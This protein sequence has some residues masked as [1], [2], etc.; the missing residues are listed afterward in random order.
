MRWYLSYAL[1]VLLIFILW[2]L[3]Y[4]RNAH[5]AIPFGKESSTVIASSDGLLK[6]GRDERTVTGLGEAVAE[7][8]RDAEL[9][10]HGY[11]PTHWIRNVIF[12]QFPPLQRAVLST[13]ENVLYENGVVLTISQS[14]K[15]TGVAWWLIF[16]I[17][18]LPLFLPIVL[19]KQRLQ[20]RRLRAGL[21]PEC[22]YDLR[23][24]PG[25]CPECGWGLNTSVV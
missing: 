25:R 14:T 22:G 7:I 6:V 11:D 1:I 2:M 12:P 5:F 8:G 16:V 9:K 23:A 13:S 15:V 10:S 3:S 20:R 18:A 4:A 21:C 24:T 19:S 17:L